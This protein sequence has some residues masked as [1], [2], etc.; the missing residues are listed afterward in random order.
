MDTCLVYVTA[1]NAA[2]AEKIASVIVEERL[3][4]CANI[5]GQITSIFRWEGQLQNESEVA[6]I[7]KSQPRLIENLTA[8]VIELHSYDCPCVV[9]LPITGG[10]PNFLRWIFEETS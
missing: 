7:L 10:N 4:A 2:E 9:A 3:A 6:L 8:R 1:G 5:L